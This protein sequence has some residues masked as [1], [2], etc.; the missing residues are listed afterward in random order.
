MAGDG[1]PP[2]A[3]LQQEWS[4]LAQEREFVEMNM[5]TLQYLFWGGA[6]HGRKS[7]EG[8][9]GWALLWL[10]GIPIPLLFVFFLLRGCT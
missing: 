9:I 7:K 10:M 5:K 6:L 3:F 4:R 2:V 1:P 8:K